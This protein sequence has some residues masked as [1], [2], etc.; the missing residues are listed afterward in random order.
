[1]TNLERIRQMEPA[2]LVKLFKEIRDEKLFEHIDWDRYLQSEDDRYV[3]KGK[4][5][6]L[7]LSGRVYDCLIV[8]DTEFDGRPYLRIL[9]EGNIVAVSSDKVKKTAQRRTD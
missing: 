7:Y 9:W 5:A 2:R 6:R 1:M 3:Y 8:G 4:P